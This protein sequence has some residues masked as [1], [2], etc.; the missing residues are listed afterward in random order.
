MDAERIPV[1][2]GVG[3][4]NDRPADPFAGLDSLGLMAAAARAADVD[5][6][7]GWLT[8]LD[9]VAVVNQISFPALGDVSQPL[10][11]MLGARPRLCAQTAYPSGASPVRLLNE[12]ASAIA[13]GEIGAALIAGG[14]A[15]RTA[16]QRAAASAGG[17]ASDH[18]ATRRASTRSAPDYRQRYG[19]IAPVD[20]Y[21]LYENAMRAAL[22]QTLAD[23]Q[24]ESAAMWAGMSEVAAQNEAAWLRAPVSAAEILA[25]SPNNRPIAFPYTKLMVA[26]SS[27]NQGAAFIVASL[28]AARRH[29]VSEERLIYIGY[30]AAADEPA[31]ILKRDRFDRS[32]SM[33]VSLRRTLELNA[34]G[35]AEIDHAELYSCFPCVPKLARRA[36]GWPADRPITVVGGL[37][38]GGGPI[39]NYMSHAGASMAQRLRDGGGTGLLFANGGFAT[40]NHSIVLSSDPERAMREARSFDYQ[41]EADEARAPAPPVDERYEGP[42]EIETYTVFY[43]REG[44]PRA[45][46]VVGRSEAGARLLAKV[47]GDDAEAIAFLTNGA[48][49][50]VGARGR[51][52]REGDDVIWRL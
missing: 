27:V 41:A 38:F 13:L 30:G 40:Q 32:V 23:A 11:Q 43:T 44:A 2:V 42:A 28:A 17:S 29:G 49:E 35:V 16:A 33:A 46:V 24:A 34:L 37:T 47:S 31:N 52:V 10:A 12:A 20:V 7:G 22:G 3:Q 4:I 26:N 36:I 51:A 9:S 45:G 50:P 8:R 48:A 1:I 39:G 21:P 19:L 15:L 5:A 25:P 14:E 6:G 18:E